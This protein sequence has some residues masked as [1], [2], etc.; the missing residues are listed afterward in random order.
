M[1]LEKTKHALA[2]SAVVAGSLVLLGVDASAFTQGPQYWGVDSTTGRF[3]HDASSVAVGSPDCVSDT[4][5]P[6]SM[7]VNLRVD[8]IS[9][10]DLSMGTR[11][12]ECGDSTTFAN[13][14]SSTDSSRYRGH[15]LQ[16]RDY[17]A[18]GTLN[19]K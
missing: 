11:S 10:P 6:Y 1:T 8:V 7:K 3:H 12:F 19:A 14:Q 9:A 17:A 13:G 2:G 16:V 5:A 4:L 18:Y 15:F